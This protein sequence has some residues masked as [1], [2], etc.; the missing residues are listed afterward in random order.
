MDLGTFLRSDAAAAP[1]IGVVL[2]VA[3]TVVL[4]AVVG[5]FAIGLGAGGPES[6]PT[7]KFDVEYD[8]PKLQVIHAG[9]EAV[10]GGK[11]R[12]VSQSAT[13]EWGSGT[14]RAGD[15]LTIDRNHGEFERGGTV[16]VVWVTEGTSST[17]RT[18]EV[19]G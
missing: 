12:V 19:P 4:A 7:A 15:G 1:V 16:R 18:Y 5:T 6:P 13:I 17:L 14:V 10:A 2:M 8:D 9:G 11:L 3:V